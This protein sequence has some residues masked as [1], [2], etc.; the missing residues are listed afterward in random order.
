MDEVET[1]TPV[2]GDCNGNREHI[3]E[4]ELSC[5]SKSYSAIIRSVPESNLSTGSCIYGE[6]AGLSENEIINSSQDKAVVNSKT[7]VSLKE[8][9]S[10][11]RMLIGEFSSVC[12]TY[13]QCTWLS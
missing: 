4:S 12:G 6:S 13:T 7:E 5:N 3:F 9:G 1:R 8:I 2:K 10:T 11:H